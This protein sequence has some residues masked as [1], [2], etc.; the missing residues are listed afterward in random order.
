MN[1][2]RYLIDFSNRMINKGARIVER[3]VRDR[4]NVDIVLALALERVTRNR[5]IHFPS[6]YVDLLRDCMERKEFGVRRIKGDAGRNEDVSEKRFCA[7]ADAL[8]ENVP[9]IE[10]SSAEEIALI[11][12]SCRGNWERAESGKW[13]GDV[14]A[15]FEI[16][17]SFGGKGRILSA[18]VRFM[19]SKRCLELG[20]GYGMSALFIL[21]ALKVKGGNGHLSTI[22]GAEPQFSVASGI[23]KNRYGNQVSCHF[24]WAQEVLPKIVKS[25]EG[26]DFLFHDATHSKEDYVRDFEALLPVLGP[27]SVVLFD[28]IYW[29]DPRFFTGNPHSYEGW[30]E[31]VKHP[32][33]RRA[34]EIKTMGL[35]LLG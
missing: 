21:E 15:H 10:F 14:S 13:A 3:E 20:T 26:L 5:D 34:I 25:L 30:R 35:I 8:R 27:G 12:D 16:S 18:V 28:D 7:L 2:K 33:V 19:Q 22:E 9:A 23:L 4:C 17:S 11:A 24:G 32:R 1:I 31:V 6:A 29:E